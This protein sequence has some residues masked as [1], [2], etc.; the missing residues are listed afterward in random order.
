MKD[1]IFKKLLKLHLPEDYVVAHQ[2]YH[3]TIEL[4]DFLEELN[5]IHWES[6]KYIHGFDTNE[7]VEWKRTIFK[8][9]HTYITTES[10]FLNVSRNISDYSLI[11]EYIDFTWN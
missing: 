3:W 4:I 11:E 1:D 8:K 2:K 6:K 5:L 7:S 9:Y 10:G